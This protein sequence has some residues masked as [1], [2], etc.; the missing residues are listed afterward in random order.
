MLLACQT[1]G[2]QHSPRTA[3]AV[4]PDACAAAPAVN[5]LRHLINPLV[6][7]LVTHNELEVLA[8][9]VVHSLV[10]DVFQNPEK[11]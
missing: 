1:T 9:D 5:V 3:G 7:W 2:M 6:S 8:P 10:M 11:G 4:M